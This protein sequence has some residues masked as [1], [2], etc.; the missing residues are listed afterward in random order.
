HVASAE[1]V[2]TT[3]AAAS[4]PAGIYN[5]GTGIETSVLELAEGCKR[6]SGV[7]AEIVFHP[8][9]LGEVSPR[10]LDPPP[11]AGRPS[12]QRP[13]AVACRERARVAPGDLA[14]RGARRDVEIRAGA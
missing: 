8:P 3:L 9:R 14:R 5:V 6:A 12:P 13:R 4:G 7:D 2:A 1:V 11:A 10:V